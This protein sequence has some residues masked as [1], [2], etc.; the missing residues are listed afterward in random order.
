MGITSGDNQRP[1]AKFFGDG[2][3][4]IDRART[5]DDAR[6]GGKFKF[7]HHVGVQAL[8]CFEAR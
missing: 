2:A 8:V 4:V 3:G 6:G 1:A 7:H 5:E